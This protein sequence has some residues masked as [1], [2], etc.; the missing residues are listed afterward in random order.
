[1]HM[2]LTAQSMSLYQWGPNRN[3]QLG[4]P[5][6]LSSPYAE[7]CATSELASIEQVLMLMP[8]PCFWAF[9]YIISLGLDNNKVYW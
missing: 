4:N 6:W 7:E 1:M 5:R 9:T 2:Q 3:S 8:G